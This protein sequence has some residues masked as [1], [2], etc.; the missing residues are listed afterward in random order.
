M[1]DQPTDNTP[2][3]T[4]PKESLADKLM[5]GVGLVLFAGNFFGYVV[6]SPIAKVPVIGQV[7]NFFKKNLP[8]D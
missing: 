7:N 5:M 6:T 4:T 3:D 2:T 8:S 1:T